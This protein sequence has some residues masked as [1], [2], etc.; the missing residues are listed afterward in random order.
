VNLFNKNHTHSQ[1]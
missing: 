1:G